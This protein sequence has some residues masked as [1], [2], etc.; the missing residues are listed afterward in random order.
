MADPP[1]DRGGARRVRLP[2]LRPHRLTAAGV[3]GVPFRRPWRPSS[4]RA[5]KTMRGARVAGQERPQLRIGIQCGH[6]DAAST[7]M[8]AAST[9]PPPAR[10]ADAGTVRLGGRDVAGLLLCGDM[11]GVP[12]DMLAGFLGVRGDRGRATSPV[13]YPDHES[14]PAPGPRPRSPARPEPGRVSA[15]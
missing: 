14:C 10:R 5:G 6:M 3:A 7:L 15:T 1:P 4:G 2:P 9:G 11:Y 13:K 12:Y 8:T